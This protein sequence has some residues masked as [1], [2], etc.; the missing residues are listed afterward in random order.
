MQ[1]NDLVRVGA[2]AYDHSYTQL[3][4]QGRNK[5]NVSIETSQIDGKQG[6]D[7]VALVTPV[8]GCENASA[9]GV[10]QFTDNLTDMCAAW[11]RY[12]SVATDQVHHSLTGTPHGHGLEPITVWAAGTSFR[13][14]VLLL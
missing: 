14:G 1:N 8:S 11:N 7:L 5:C 3:Y 4:M 9:L 10:L 12:G 2:H 6:G 13:C